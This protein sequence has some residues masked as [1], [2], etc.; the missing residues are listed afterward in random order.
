MTCCVEDIQFA[1][2]VCQWKEAASV[3]DGRWIIL[4]ASIHFKFN[5]AY[6]KRGPVLTL[7]SMEPSEEPEQAV[8]TFY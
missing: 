6:G 2:L 1:G 3:S 7:L 4:T 5:R 8:A